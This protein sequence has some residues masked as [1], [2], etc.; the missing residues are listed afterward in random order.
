MQ[1]GYTPFEPPAT[2][3]NPR[4]VPPPAEKWSAVQCAQQTLSPGVAG[5]AL[6]S[7]HVGQNT[8]LGGMMIAL[9]E[10]EEIKVIFTQVKAKE[11]FFMVCQ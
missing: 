10:M 5:L 11:D 4:G 6:G 7:S 9:F 3:H 1:R 2:F 8:H